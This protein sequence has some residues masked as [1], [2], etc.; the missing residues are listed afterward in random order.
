MGRGRPV[1]ANGACQV[2]REQVLRSNG[3]LFYTSYAEFA[4]CL[5]LLCAQPQL[6]QQ[7]GQQGRQFVE[8]YYSWAAVERRLEAALTAAY[9]IVHGACVPSR[10]LQEEQAEHD[11]EVA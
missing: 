1:L 11:A 8:R 2:L 7:M 5:D 4:A 9:E 3:G 10:A 6:A